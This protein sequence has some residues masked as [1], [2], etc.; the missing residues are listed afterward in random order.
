MFTFWEPRGSVPAYLR[1]CRETWR[2][3]SPGTTIEQ[4]DYDNFERYTGPNVVD[5]QTLKTLP[6]PLQKDAILFAV[7]A[8]NGGIF[9]DMDTIVF[10]DLSGLLGKLCKTELLMFHVH[11]GVVAARPGSQLVAEC[12]AEVRQRLARLREERETIK[13]VHWDYLGNSILHDVLWQASRRNSAISRAQGAVLGGLSRVLSRT[14]RRGG[15]AAVFLHRV[16][17]F[18]ATQVIFRFAHRDRLSMLN[19]DRHGF[20]AERV[21]GNRRIRDPQQKYLEYW[22]GTGDESQRAIPSQSPVIG[23]H[24]SWT[25]SWYVSLSEAE[26]LDHQCLLSRTLRKALGLRGSR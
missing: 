25:P 5:L 24:H 6:L 17:G 20:I 12:L 2:R 26:V 18:I 8:Q 14:G 9:M 23:L 16:D 13:D 1:L 10:T 11:M 3:N 7:L 15:Q 4:L 21:H 19:R 22:F